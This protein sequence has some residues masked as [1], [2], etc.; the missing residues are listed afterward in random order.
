LTQTHLTTT[1]ATT[2]TCYLA[3]ETAC[4]YRKNQNWKLAAVI[5]KS[6]RERKRLDASMVKHQTAFII[7]YAAKLEAIAQMVAEHAAP[8]VVGLSGYGN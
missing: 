7:A 3:A 8:P 4:T 6:R 2:G 1:T 5:T